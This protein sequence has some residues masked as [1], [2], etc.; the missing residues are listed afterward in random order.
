MGKLKRLAGDTVLYGL[1][2]ILPKFLNFL[3]VL[4]H[5]DVF[6]PAEYGIITNLY[7]YVTFINVLFTFGM[8]TAYFRFASKPGAD[9]KKIFNLT[10]T[11][12][13]SISLILS[14]IIIGF[15]QPIAIQLD[16]ESQSNYVIWIVAI[17]FI[18]SVVAIPFARLRLQNRPLKFA[19]GRILNILILVGLNV[20]FLIYAYDQSIGVAYVFI[21]NLTANVFYL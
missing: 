5:T 17:L 12:V 10:Q 9:E 14:L 1:G 21:A 7:A 15:A 11:V 4:L 2:S 19:F 6:L 8:E 16:I 20:Y 13:V 18:D 3:L